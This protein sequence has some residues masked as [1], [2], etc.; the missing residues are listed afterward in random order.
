MTKSAKPKMRPF[1]VVTGILLFLPII[2]FA[3]AAPVS[4][5]QKPQAR[6]DVVKIPENAANMLGRRGDELYEMY[7]DLFG[8][9]EESSAAHLPSGPPPSESGPS[10][11]LM[12]VDKQQQFIPKEPSQ[13]S[14][15]DRAAAPPTLSDEW[16]TMWRNVFKSHFPTGSGA[17]RPP[18]SS[19]LSEPTDVSTNVEQPLLSIPKEPSQ[20]DGPGNAPQSLG[21]QWNKMWRNLFES[22][23]P[24]KAEKSAPSITE[25]PSQVPAP[26]H[27]LPSTGSLTDS[28]Y[29]LMK[30]DVPREPSTMPSADHGLMEVQALPNPRPSAESNHEMM[31][32]LQ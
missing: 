7:L 16:N 17:V 14:S 20:L 19:Q 21:D 15:P 23:F 10:D 9:S 32:V 2:D 30:G 27:A 25:E 12:N 13:V 3:V 24:E 1:C 31:D 5:G 26:D 22:H 4:V 29:E 11:G 18:P 6:V 8:H 28:G